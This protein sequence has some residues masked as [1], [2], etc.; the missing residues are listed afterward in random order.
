MNEYS[1]LM[2]RYKCLSRTVIRVYKHNIDMHMI[3][4][5]CVMLRVCICEYMHSV[6][7]YDCVCSDVIIC[8]CIY[9]Y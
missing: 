6:H 7:M 5:V 9:V 4:S 2:N 3:M 1:L 8:K